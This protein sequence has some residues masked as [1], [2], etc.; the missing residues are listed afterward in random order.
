[1]FPLSI[2]IKNIEHVLPNLS[3]FDY[4]YTNKLQRIVVRCGTIFIHLHGLHIL[5][6]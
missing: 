5:E 6:D 4:I 1:M 2:S 3:F